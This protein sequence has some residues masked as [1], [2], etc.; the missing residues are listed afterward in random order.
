MTKRLYLNEARLAA[1]GFDPA[2]IATLRKLTEFVA[3]EL[4]QRE[5]QQQLDAADADLTTLS[6]V[7]V[8]EQANIDAAE[9]AIEDLDARLTTAESNISTNASDIAA[10]EARVA[11]NEADIAAL[12]NP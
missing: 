12:Q 11:Q 6:L 10:L 8:Q 1:I 4:E 2:M 7:V 3:L 5:T 9:D